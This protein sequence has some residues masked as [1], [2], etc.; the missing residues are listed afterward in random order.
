MSSRDDKTRAFAYRGSIPT[1]ENK[2]YT[3]ELEFS[4]EP[5]P[6]SG[7]ILRNNSVVEE[8]VSFELIL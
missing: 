6:I 7:I 2:K 3:F 5:D 8:N 1:F 4:G